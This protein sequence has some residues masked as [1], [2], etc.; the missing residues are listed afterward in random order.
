MEACSRARQWSRC[1]RSSID[2]VSVTPAPASAPLASLTL[3]AAA[4]KPVLE[5]LTE[6]ATTDTGLSSN[7]AARR[8]ATFGPNVL[9]SR[10]V[11]VFG[12]LSRQLRNPLLILLLAAA[13][14][15][16]AT[17]DVT[18]GG[19]IATIVILSVG[20]GFVNEYRSEIA[21]AALHGNIRH[22]ALVWRDNTARQIATKYRWSSNVSR[23][24]G[25]ARHSPLVRPRT[26]SSRDP[27][28]LT[29]ARVSTATAGLKILRVNQPG[30]TYLGTGA[31]SC[32]GEALPLAEVFAQV[33]GAR[34]QRRWP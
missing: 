31:E 24:T 27:H 7:E 17:G 20:L 23:L 6:L 30:L 14:V 11:T 33:H 21:V 16:A 3:S 8:L 18:D 4:R 26:R 9:L 28:T 13:A 19:I 5:T 12:V 32:M 29:P 25:V 2:D 22:E 10:T 15:S 1:S 34:R